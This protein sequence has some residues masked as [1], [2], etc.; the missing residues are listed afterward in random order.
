MYMKT[1]R[2]FILSM[3]VCFATT[4]CLVAEQ[5]DEAVLI[6]IED[7]EVTRS[8]FEK[9][10]RRNNLDLMVND[11]KEVDEYLEMYINF[12]LK[13]ME[14]KSIGL[15]TN[16]S[17]IQ[18]LQGYR[19]QLAQQYLR[20]REVTEA[21]V[22]EAWERS[23]YDIR[24]SHL[25]INLDAYAPPEDTLEV[26]TR[27]MELRQRAM[28]GES[29]AGLA[30][31]YSDDPSARDTEASGNRPPRKGNAGDLGYF[32]ALNMVYPFESAAYNT[33]VGEISGPVRTNFGYHLVKV[34]NRQPAMGTARVAHIMLMTPDGT[35]KDELLEKEQ[36]INDLYQRIMAGEDFGELAGEYSEDRQ[37]AQR[38][39]E[40]PSFTSNRMVPQ[41]IG[42][43]N[44][45]D[46]PGDVSP[47]V[48]SDFG[49]HIIKLIEKTPPPSF[50]EA[51]DN[52]RRRIERDARAQLSETVVIDR[53]KEEYG[54]TYDMDALRDFYE[55][56]DETIFQGEWDKTGTSELDRQLISFGSKVLGQQDFAKFLYDKQRSQDAENIPSYVYRRYNEF[57]KE[58]ILAYE[59]ERLEEK[60]PEFKRVMQEY[61]DGIL[62]FEITDQ[63]VWSKATADTAGLK[64]FFETHKDRYEAG[65]LREVRGLVIADYQN[66]L[67]EQWIEVLRNKYSVYVDEELLKTIRF[68]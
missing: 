36:Q 12:R 26:Y 19:Q 8:E 24:A 35:E 67:E 39:G 2:F 54:F 40:M 13:V 57:V 37:S 68:D 14:A 27:I 5:K 23:Q 29:F 28:E 41:F 49:W 60:Y 21:L 30:I 47:P 51:Y 33:P 58:N 16:E 66:Y 3:F 52:L 20:D 38:N 59:N 25:L 32:S 43:I 6:R 46:E 18:E 56:V 42:A 62:L 63:E 31:E 10:Y 53:L 11:P 17:F 64:S 61:H 22:R 44:D 7:R 55:V 1:M 50:D 9:I 34:V 48:R 15:D 4:T 45:L 65:E